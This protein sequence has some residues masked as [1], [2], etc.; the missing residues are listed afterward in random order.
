MKLESSQNYYYRYKINSE[1]DFLQETVERRLKKISK[2]T[3]RSVL[4]DMCDSEAGFKN[5]WPEHAATFFK[6]YKT[7]YLFTLPHFRQ[8]AAHI[9][10]PESTQV[11]V[12]IRTL[13]EFTELDQFLSSNHLNY[14][15]I[16]VHF[17]PR[18]TLELNTFKNFSSDVKSCFAS[19]FWDFRPYN[20]N[21]KHS[22]TIKDIGQFFHLKNHLAIETKFTQGLLHGLEIWNDHIPEHYELEPNVHASWVYATP[23]RDLKL[24]IVIPSFNNAKFLANVVNHLITQS[25]S[26][27]NYEI[28]VVEDGGTD[29][30]CEVIK[31]LFH[32]YRNKVNL[33]FIYWSKKHPT[34]GDQQFFRAGLARNLGVYFSESAN[35]MF[36]D[37]DM[38]VPQNFVQICL[39]ELNKNDLIQFQRYHIQQ[40]I[41]GLNPSYTNVQKEKET[42]IEEKNY[43]SELFNCDD[44]MKLNNFWK[45]TC[46]YALGLKK[47]DFLAVGRFKKYYISY[48]FED[49]DLGYEMFKRQKNFK[50]IQTPLFHLTAYDHMQYRNSQIKRMQL[51]KKTSALFYLQH[52]DSKIFDTFQ[53]F[54]RFEK[55]FLN[56]LK[57]LL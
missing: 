18:T 21:I 51:L 55:P 36:L 26:P 14:L 24:S 7:E 23:S 48:G 16:H 53:N 28:I 17:S 41:S 35:L 10:T 9:K 32:N 6:N 3:T 15:S 47:S 4:I 12:Q 37:S 54:Y 29:H 40:S 52:L 45:Y 38:L 30:S 8:I 2:N 34:K 57:D 43:W 42:Y 20:A 27:E 5:T 19:Y 50:L 1:K 46:T 25:I 44:W 39:D 49:T 22:L 56:R 11:H 31:T 13:F 33:K